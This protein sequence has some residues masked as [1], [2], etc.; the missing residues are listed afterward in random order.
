MKPTDPP[1]KTAKTGKGE[2]LEI[3][4]ARASFWLVARSRQKKSKE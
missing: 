2:E 4:P 1:P 3:E